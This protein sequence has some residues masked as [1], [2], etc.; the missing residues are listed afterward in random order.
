MQRAHFSSLLLVLAVASTAT[1]QA[2]DL[3]NPLSGSNIDTYV[4]NTRDRPPRENLVRALKMF[5]SEWRPRET[6][7][8]LDIGA[9]AGNETRHLLSMGWNVIAVDPAKVA[10][11]AI[12]QTVAQLKEQQPE[13]SLGELTC[14]TS[15]IQDVP[16]QPNS[17]DL[18]NASYS[19]PFVPQ[20]EITEVW[21]ECA[22]ALRPGGVF[23]GQFFGP[24]HEWRD[25]KGMS[26]FSVRQLF[27]RC[28]TADFEVRYLMHERKT[29]N[30]AIG[31][32]AYFDVI[33]VIAQ[34]VGD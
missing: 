15:G 13:T 2:N 18:I 26:F 12:R 19:L 27:E 6:K 23:T 32:T 28:F 3:D 5:A 7:T 24:N 20:G 8:A 31:G 14:H 21:Q 17:I 11:D 9:G 25:R 22:A 29:V 1:A 34:K 16:L 4:N 33:T 30:L 10:T